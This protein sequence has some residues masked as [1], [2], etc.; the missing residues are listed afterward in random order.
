MVK[1][2]PAIE[3]NARDLKVQSLNQEDLQEQE[4]AA[5][6]SIPPWK[7]PWAEEPGGL[8]PW[9]CKGLERTE[10]ICT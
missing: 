7:I 10:H 5:H 2:P 1:N 6:S 9:G 3:G 4:M 8:S